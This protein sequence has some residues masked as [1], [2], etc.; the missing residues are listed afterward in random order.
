MKTITISESQEKLINEAL[1]SRVQLPSHI[2]SDIKRGD[3]PFDSTY[4]YNGKLLLDLAVKRFQEVKDAFSD[5][6]SAYDNKKIVSELSRLIVKCRKK[7]EG[8]REQ[9]EK[10]CINSL[11]ELF[12]VPEDGVNIDAEIVPEISNRTQFH[13]TPDTDENFEYED[14]ESIKTGDS[15]VKKRCIIDAIIVGAAMRLSEMAFKN[16]FS[17]IFDIDEDL[18]HLYS[19]IM[20][21][22]DYL[23]FSQPFEIEDNSHKQGG[24]VE[25]TLGND[26]TPSKIEAR[27]VM[28][29]MLLIELIRGCMEL[30]ASNGLPDNIDA[31]RAAINKADALVNDPWYSR[32]GPVLWDKIYDSIPEF[33][34]KSL[35][36]FIMELSSIPTEDFEKKM[37]EVFAGTKAGK[38][39]IEE[40]SEKAKYDDEY[41]SFE[42]DIKQKQSERG[43][44]EDEYFREDE[45]NDTI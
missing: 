33:D 41:S 13:I 20:K 43:V 17:K 12:D 6:I 23:L 5:D 26:V 34:T 36:T 2:F 8:I 11:L 22:N 21:I 27:A 31:A 28:A 40:I 37:S 30:W 45:L 7:E 16:S 35:P 25:V 38:K 10:I 44:I 19:K 24:Y 29:P 9:L 1:I 15:E 14:V 42:Y 4:F 32:L 39:F 18:P 3:V